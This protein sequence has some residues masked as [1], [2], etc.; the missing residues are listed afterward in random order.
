MYFGII[1]KL[2][3]IFL[4]NSFFATNIIVESILVAMPGH[5]VSRRLRVMNQIQKFSAGT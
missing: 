4:K 1:F 5:L 2:Y 3:K